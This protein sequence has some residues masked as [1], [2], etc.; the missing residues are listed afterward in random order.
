[1]WR[2]LIGPEPSRHCA[3]IG[4][5]DGV[6]I[7]RLNFA[8]FVISG[9]STSYPGDGDPNSRGSCIEARFTAES[10][11]PSPPVICGTNTGHHM[12][13][14]ARQEQACNKLTFTWASS[15]STEPQW[16]IQ[17]MQI[18]CSA[19]WKPPAGCLQFFTGTTGVLY[20]YNY[21][22]ELHLANQQ[23]D[24]CIRTEEG[25]CS[26]SYSS[27][28]TTSFQISSIAPSTSAAIAQIGENCSED[29]ITIPGGGQTSG[30]STS[31]DRQ[32]GPASHWSRSLQIRCSDWSNFLCHKDTRLPKP[33]TRGIS[34]LSLCLCGIRVGCKQGKDLL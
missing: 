26:I 7:S 10:D 19:H 17:V 27:L 15:A 1:M 5:D 22:G 25:H 30:A 2:P 31:S 28:S 3:L 14:E 9:P 6:A 18:S 4:W 21:G 8:K 32:S 16:N 29:W 13:L 20:S 12:I 34:C 33:P 23:Y 24:L 11:G